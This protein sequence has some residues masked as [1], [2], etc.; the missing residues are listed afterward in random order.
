MTQ[1]SEQVGHSL[2]RH[3]LVGAFIL[4]L[5]VAGLGGWAAFASI[6]GAVIAPSIVVVESNAKQVQHLEGGIVSEIRVTDGDQVK[7]GDLLIRLDDTETRANLGVIDTQLN[8]LIARRDRLLAERDGNATIRFSDDVDLFL[9]SGTIV[10]TRNGQIKLFFSRQKSVEGEK[11][12]LDRRVQQLEE[13]IRGLEAQRSSR[14]SQLALIKDELIGINEL[15]V[16]GLVSKNRL[17]ALQREDARLEGERG[18]FIANIARAK[19]R[20]AETR[21]QAS[22][23]ERERLSD[24]L[25]EL[26]E[27]QARVA[28]MIERRGSA[29]SRLKRINI[30]APRAG[31]VH[32][33]AVH[34]IGGVVAPRQP[35]MAIIPEQD[36]LQLEARVD[37]NN[38]HRVYD[39]QPVV[40]RFSS[41]NVRK[42]PEIEGVVTRV[43]AATTKND[44][45][46]PPYYIVRI[47]IS[48]GEL[49]KLGGQLLKPGMPAEVFIDTG[50]RKAISYLMKP[51]MDA[52][53]KIW[54]GE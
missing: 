5:M 25:T 22:Q 39:D 45:T 44:G 29:V 18:Q 38:I 10:R 46:M 4:A 40:I 19:G 17:L 49:D 15:A 47:S 50:D 53:P 33:L 8:E 24:V 11:E 3:Q 36:A 32:D 42:T 31:Y 7:A 20:I 30:H 14:H 41:L 43:P 54:R 6:S 37:P 13:E 2:K 27:V 48:D 26:R 23:V 1:R 52:L 28:E 35:I 16:Q 21:V 9:D 51:F 12:Q 34:T